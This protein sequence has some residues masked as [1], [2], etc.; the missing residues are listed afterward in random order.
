M[1]LGEGGVV[2]GLMAADEGISTCKVQKLTAVTLSPKNSSTSEMIEST[3][4]V[5][6]AFV[7]PISQLS[8]SASSTLRGEPGGK[9]NKETLVRH[10]MQ[11]CSV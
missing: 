4:L 8:S 11:F 6:F 5:K 7:L 3:G 2:T 9:I 1:V 10:K